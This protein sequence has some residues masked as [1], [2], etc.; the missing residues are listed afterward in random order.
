MANRLV[1]TWQRVNDLMN[2]KH[3]IMRSPD[4]HTAA[5]V[6]WS[7]LKTAIK[8]V[9]N[10]RVLLCSRTWGHSWLM[11]SNR[12][13]QVNPKHS[14][15]LIWSETRRTKHVSSHHVHP[16]RMLT[17]LLNHQTPPTIK[18]GRCDTV[19]IL[20]SLRAL[21]VVWSILKTRSPRKGMLKGERPRQPSV[22]SL[23]TEVLK[24]NYIKG[25]FWTRG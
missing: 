24:S 20:D 8:T 6:K 17:I 2:R 5:L 19:I 25:L 1:R 21:H 9:W 14:V 15:W 16:P 13:R 4:V 18:H 23:Q 7:P 3:V 22:G 11:P 10:E 12:L